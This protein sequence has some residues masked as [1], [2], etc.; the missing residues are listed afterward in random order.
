MSYI[1]EMDVTHLRI[2]YIL[3]EGLHCFKI[4]TNLYNWEPY[5]RSQIEIMYQADILGPDL[6]DKNRFFKTFES[7]SLQALQ[8]EIRKYFILNPYKQSDVDKCPDD[9]RNSVGYPL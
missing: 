9:D 8:E 2:S 4:E 3:P 7:T 6:E 1:Y 5:D